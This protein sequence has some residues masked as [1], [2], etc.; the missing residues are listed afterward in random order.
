MKALIQRVSRA[1]VTVDGEVIGSIGGGLAALVGVAAGDEKADIDY[2]VNKI[3]NLRIFA[4]ADSK[5][6]L[7]L[8]DVKGELLLISQFTL[9]ADTRKGRRPSFTDAA[10]PETA[11]FMFDE[12]VA[13][14]RNLGVKVE[15]GRF[16]AHMFVELVNDGPVTIMLD[17]SDR[18]RARG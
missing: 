9:M 6:N 4:D 10:P 16:Q 3:V 5:F 14:A 15:T 2:L 12:F 17:S 13:E 8:L 11:E 7:S 18:L 1:Q